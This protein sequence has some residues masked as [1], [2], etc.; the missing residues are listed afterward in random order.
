M[1]L[2]KQAA[3]EILHEIDFTPKGETERTTLYV[4]A[5]NRMGASNHLILN[6]IWGKQHEIRIHSTN[7]LK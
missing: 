7:L 6:K 5:K 1:A 2:N 3:G 4:Y